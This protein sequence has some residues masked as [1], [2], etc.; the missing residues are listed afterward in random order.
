MHKL[1][2][3]FIVLVFLLCTGMLA[4]GYNLTSSTDVDEL[5]LGH[6]LVGMAIAGFFFVAM[7]VFIYHRW[8]NKKVKDYMLT[9]ENILKM[10]AFNDSKKS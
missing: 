7:P 8:K 1:R 9:E 4:Y 5:R 6:K 10:K 2:R 3:I